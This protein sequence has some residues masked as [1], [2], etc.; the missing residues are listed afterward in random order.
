MSQQARRVGTAPVWSF[1]QLNKTMNRP[2]IKQTMTGMSSKTR[3]TNRKVHIHTQIKSS[4]RAGRPNVQRRWPHSRKPSHRNP[5][6]SLNILSDMWQPHTHTHKYT[7]LSYSRRSVEKQV[8]WD[9]TQGLCQLESALIAQRNHGIW[10]WV[11]LDSC[12][13]S[14]RINEL[15]TQPRCCWRHDD[16]QDKTLSVKPKPYPK[17]TLPLSKGQRSKVKNEHCIWAQSLVLWTRLTYLN[18]ILENLV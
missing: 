8:L 17:K 13:S 16:Q 9:W 6:V 14:P 3:H 10:A 4:C 12:P 2:T 11:N 5:S 15:A 18:N 7:W 1:Q